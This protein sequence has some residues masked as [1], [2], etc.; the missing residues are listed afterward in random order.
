MQNL[1]KKT[2]AITAFP[3]SA[4][5]CRRILNVQAPQCFGVD[6][7]RYH[8]DID[9]Y[10]LFLDASKLIGSKG[11]IES[12]RIRSSP[13]TSGRRAFYSAVKKHLL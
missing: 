6:F 1:R 9:L 5:F 3:P 4:R 12:E 10:F 7:C 8:S 2:V 13:Q 11:A